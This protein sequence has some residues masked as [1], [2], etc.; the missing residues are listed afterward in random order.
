MTS[1]LE[2]LMRAIPAAALAM[3]VTV[4]GEAAA[5][6]GDG[7][8]P[9]SDAGDPYY[10]P[11]TPYAGWVE[12][13]L[14]SSGTIPADGV[15][16]LQAG[17]REEMPDLGTAALTV[18]T[19][20]VPMGGTFEA[21][22]LPG[23]LLWRPEAAW[24]PGAT[25]TIEGAASNAVADGECIQMTLPVSGEVTIDV[26]AGAALVPVDISAVEMVNLSPTVAL[27]T[28]ACCEGVTPTV[29]YGGCS[30]EPLVEFDPGQCTPF[31]GTGY[32][33]LTLTGTS[34]G[35]GS[36]EQQI[37]YVLRAAGQPE[38]MAFTPMFGIGG[39][40]TS[41]CAAIDAID[42]GTGA[43]TPG[44]MECFGDGV[45]AQLGPQ[46]IDPA[47]TLDCPLQVC[48]IDELGEGWDP[49]MCTP[50]G[51]TG[52]PTGGPEPT[53]SG[54]AS[55]EASGDGTGGQDDDDKGCACAAS[56][57]GGPPLLGLLGLGWLVRRR[58][59]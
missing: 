18:T 37:L 48:A 28:L 14:M 54:D 53:E 9:A 46:I 55:S 8:C 22:Q 52:E 58:R 11:C 20:G 57:P 25:Y 31:T 33:S 35:S 42:L 17:W 30:G 12:L 41:Q 39:L 2:R 10:D 21:T 36:V 47:A 50:Y 56:A 34:A 7:A 43:V 26:E 49:T 5:E 15:L 13:G 38:S 3:T 40:T 23:L 44:E 45:L 59:R 29:S 32:L 24:T 4:A 1:G 19:D 51:G 6:V 16:L 27:D